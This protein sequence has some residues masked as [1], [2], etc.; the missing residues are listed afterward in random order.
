MFLLHLL[1]ESLVHLASL[2]TLAGF[3]FKEQVILR[4]LVI[5]GTLF[6]I[7]FYFLVPAQPMWDAIFWNSL[8]VAV[9]FAYLF[10]LLRDRKPG[11]M[12]PREQ[13]LYNVFGRL[14]PGQFR[15]LARH[16]DWK[17]AGNDSVLTVEG[18]PVT[19]LY[20]V[21]SGKLEITKRGKSRTREGD[22]FVGEVAYLQKRR[23]SATVKLAKGTKY[24]EWS[25]GSLN[26]ML[27]RDSEMNTAMLA[28]LSADLADKVARS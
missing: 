20:Y 18:L 26:K 3:F 24:V 1:K 28:V 5:L 13:A 22:M 19:S 27:G 21:F 14:S 16:A 9:N 4:G 8:L 10:M 7:A 17:V 23:A 25:S 6:Y 2:T 15:R 11:F 12:S